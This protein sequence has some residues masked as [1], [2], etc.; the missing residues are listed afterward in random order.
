MFTLA[1]SFGILSYIVFILGING[2]LTKTNLVT[3]SLV[4]IIFFFYFYK[5]TLL[6]LISSL[7][8]LIKK[9]SLFIGLIFLQIVVNFIGVLGPEISFDALWYHLSLPKIYLTNHELSF[10]PGSLMYYS[11]MPQLGEMLF[12]PGIALGG[13]EIA[14]LTHFLFGILSLF[15]LYRLSRLFLNIKFSLLVCIIFYS[16]LVVGWE[17]ISVYVDLIRTFFELSA[18]YGFFLWMKKN[19]FKWLFVF[20][21]MIGLSI[22]TKL[23]SVQSLGVFVIL[24]I[25]F[26]LISKK[27]LKRVIFDVLVLLFFSLLISLPWFFYAYLSTNN[28]IYPLFQGLDSSFIFNGVTNPINL[29]DYIKNLFLFSADPISPLYLVFIPLV[30]FTFKKYSKTEKFI[31]YYCFLAISSLYFIPGDRARFLIPYLPALSLLVV[32]S[33]KYINSKKIILYSIILIILMSIFS[34]IYRLA[35]NSKFIPYLTGRETK[36]EFLERE[37]NF[38]FGDFYDTDEYFKRNITK[39]DKV[40]LFNFHNLYYIDFPYIHSSWVKKGDR[41]NYIAVQNS[42]LPLRFRDWTLVYYNL[43]T[44][45]KLYTLNKETWEY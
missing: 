14:K 5:Y 11:A 27:K 10:I 3:L 17:S 25:F 30:V 33:F 44:K 21:S 29:V 15:V 39:N 37:L 13:E 12:L 4:Y 2:L 34:S 20:S 32:L 43:V 24:V 38:E 23:V 18:L 36:G 19:E 28:P 41:F 31:L 16:N 8:N 6:N 35:A 26:D 40:L 42:E 1:L 9:Q 7:V 22:A 45:V